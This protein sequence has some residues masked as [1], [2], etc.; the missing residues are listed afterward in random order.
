MERNTAVGVSALLACYPFMLGYIQASWR[1]N[2]VIMDSLTFDGLVSMARY[3]GPAT[4]SQFSI[5]WG[6]S[7]DETLMWK[8]VFSKF[9]NNNQL[10]RIITHG[11]R[12]FGIY[13]WTPGFFQSSLYP[14]VLLIMNNAIIFFH[15][16][17]W[18][19]HI[20]PQ[21]SEIS[22]CRLIFQ[23]LLSLKTKCVK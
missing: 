20:L 3:N 11:L 7:G 8:E 13:K 10:S 16:I 14:S 4:W 15:H 12:S 17:N 6:L 2:L 23:I 5:I 18:V 21:N 9:D 22:D 19:I 1:G